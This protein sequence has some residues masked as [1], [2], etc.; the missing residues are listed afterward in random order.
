MNNI[1]KY[2]LVSALSMNSVIAH[3]ETEKNAVIR[4]SASGEV[5]AMPD[6]INISI[7]IE[8]SRKTKTEAKTE[9]DKITRQ[10]LDALAKLNIDKKYIQASDIFARPDYEWSNNKQTIKGEIVSRT[11]NIELHALD[12]YST[13]AQTLLNINIT[14]MDQNGAGFDHIETYQNQA[15]VIALKKA[16]AQAQV[17]ADTMNT[18]IIGIQEI[19]TGVNDIPAPIYQAKFARAPMAASMASDAAMEAPL[20]ITP[21]SISSSVNISYWIKN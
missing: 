4:V 17:I 14:R 1:I 11:V 13:L 19:S 21:Q 15:L 8:K 6:F 20:E 12:N 3:C 2:L 7:A 10:V 16:Q 18:P 9:V 5:K